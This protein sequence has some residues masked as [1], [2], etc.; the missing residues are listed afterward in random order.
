MPIIRNYILPG[1]T[2]ISDLWG[3]NNTLNNDGY[4]HL[5]VNHS[6]N[7]VDPQTYACTNT[8]ESVWSHAKKRN[9]IENG[10]ARNMLDSYLI[11]FMWR[12]KNKGKLFENFFNCMR[13]IY[14]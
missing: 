11:E 3:A 8:I 13:E 10:T 7:F 6:I 5:T 12:Y 4:Y 9:N 2:I 1:T 14:D